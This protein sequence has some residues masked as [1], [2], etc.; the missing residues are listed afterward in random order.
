VI[1][2]ELDLARGVDPNDLHLRRALKDLRQSG[3]P[4]PVVVQDVDDGEAGVRG[5]R[6]QQLH[7]R[8]EAAR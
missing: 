7:E 4:P 2:G 8:I 1:T 5:Q 6:P 3:L